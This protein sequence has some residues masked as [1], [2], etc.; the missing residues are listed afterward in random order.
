M[1]DI[2]VFQVFHSDHSF[3]HEVEI[4]QSFLENPQSKI[5]S[6]QNFKHWY[7][8]YT[9]SDKGIKGIIVNQ[10]FLNRESPETIKLED[11]LNK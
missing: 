2:V 6:F 8:I 10:V 4:C 9:W 11:V 7:L 5:I 3:F 1:E